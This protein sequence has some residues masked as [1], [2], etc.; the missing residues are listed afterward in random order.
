MTKSVLTVSLLCLLAIPALAGEPFE[1]GT[2]ISPVAISETYLIDMDGVTI[3]TWLGTGAPASMAYMFPDSS[4]L[5]PAQDPSGDF[6]TG[7]SGGRIQLIDTD[8]V[9]VWD[10]LFSNTYH[11]QHHDIEPLPNGNVLLIAWE[12]KSAGEAQAMG[13]QGISTDMWPTMIVEVEPVPPDEG[14]IVWEWHIWDH[15]IQ[16][17][18]PGLPN[19]GVVADHPE[20][21]DINY[22]TVGPADGDW[23]H[24]NAI[25]YHPEFD[26]IVFS[27]RT[28]CEFYVIDH[29]TTTEE[30]AGHTGGNSGM[31]GDILYRWG[32]PRVYDRGDETHQY[33]FVIHGANWIEEGLPGAGNILTFNNGDR[34][35]TA[36][37]YS[38]VAEIVPP[39][40][41]FGNYHIAPT[42]SFGPSTPVWT[43]GDPGDFYGSP[44]NCGAFRMPNGN[45][46]ISLS[47]GGIIFEVTQAG[48]TVWQYDHPTR[49]IPRSMRYWDEG[50]GV[51]SGDDLLADGL[52]GSVSG[53]PIP[54]RSSAQLSFELAEASQAEL[55]VFDITG[56]CVANLADG[57]FT[58][59]NHH[60]S[61]NG[62]SD[63]G[64][65]LPAG[66]YF[67]RVRA[68]DETAVK[69]IVLA[70]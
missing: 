14:N 1:G 35:G 15:L 26:Q 27:S 7:G 16:D 62:R 57:D 25:D 21:I 48:S 10:F 54:F 30:A 51:E 70:R 68:A 58:A 29:S 17:L 11:Q 65:D 38:T 39:V 69:K 31:G 32:N 64:G 45:T 37:D 9:V 46:L 28:F 43:H 19:Y 6:M 63:D 2:L 55:R 5:R 8:N 44:R 24:A 4:I 40:D 41:E 53:K 23:I 61:W 3:K 34:D 49:N 50:V 60:L 47:A 13:R 12:L 33:Y 22:G 18:E 36:N 56:R 67:V 59:G 42:E 20:L 66:V 52:L